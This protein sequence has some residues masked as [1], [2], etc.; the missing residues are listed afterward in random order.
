MFVFGD[1]INNANTKIYGVALL[2]TDPL[3]EKSS[4]MEIGRV[5]PQYLG[6]LTHFFRIYLVEQQ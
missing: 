6:G 4:D 1:Y 5:W 2:V 3:C